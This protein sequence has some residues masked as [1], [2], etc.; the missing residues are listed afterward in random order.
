MYTKIECVI[1][2]K[3]RVATYVTTLEINY[4]VAVSP[5]PLLEEIAIL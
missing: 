5:P 2:L 1:K 4:A 3:K